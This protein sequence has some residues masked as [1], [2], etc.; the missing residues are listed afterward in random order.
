MVCFECVVEFLVVCVG[1]DLDE[2]CLMLCVVD[3]GFGFGVVF[4]FVVFLF[5]CVVFDFINVD[6]ISVLY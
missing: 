2:V 3:F 1:G 4:D 6:G 5:V